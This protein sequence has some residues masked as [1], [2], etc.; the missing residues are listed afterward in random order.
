ME[1]V[2]KKK[3]LTFQMS[4]TG[5]KKSKDGHRSYYECGRT[6]VHKEIDSI[7]RSIK[8]QGSKKI[9][10][11]CTSHIILFEH[12]NKSSC[13]VIFY[14]YH[15]GHQESELQHISLPITKKH[16]IATKLSQGVTMERILD[17]FRDNI[18]SN[19]KREDLITR[20]DLHNVK[21]KYNITIQDGQLH[22]NDATR[23]DIW[24]EQMKQEGENNP[25]I[26]YKKCPALHKKTILK[27]LHY[28]NGP[29]PNAYVKTIWKWKN[30]LYW[31][32][33]L[34]AYDFEL[35]TLLVVDD[36]GS[37]FP[38]CYMFTNL[39]DTTIYTVMFS[40]IKSKVGLISPITFMTDIVETFYSAWEN[41]MGSVPHRL[42]CSWHVDRAWRQNICKITGPTRKEKQGII[43]K[44]LK[45]LQSMCDENEFNNA[46]KEFN[47][48]LMNDPDTRDFGIYFDRMYGNRVGL[49]AYCHRKGLGINC[50]MHLESMHK[51][52]KYH[53]LNGCKVGRLD[54]SITTIRRYTR[55]KKVERI[56][57]LTKGKT[58]TRIQEIKKRHNK[59]T[60][61]ELTI[62]LDSENNWSV[63]SEFT[64][65][66]FYKIKKNNDDVCCPMICS[67]CKLCVH[68]FQC[69]CP[70]YQIKS[71]I[72][73]HI[74]YVALKTMSTENSEDI[75]I[76]SAA[77]T[78]NIN[79]D[80]T[81][82]KDDEIQLLDFYY[83]ASY[84]PWPQ[85][86]LIYRVK[87]LN[88]F[89][90]NNGITAIRRLFKELNSI[91]PSCKQLYIEMISYEQSL[92]S[93]NITQVSKLYNEVCYN[94]GHGDVELWAHYIRFEYMHIERYTAK[95][96]YKSSLEYLGPELFGVLTTE[97]GNIKSEYE[98]V[99]N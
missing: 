81:S 28:I 75:A 48:E 24:V 1:Y 71:M 99:Y 7:K 10:T 45:V 43:Y 20:A 18:G 3:L 8:S 31:T 59:S 61:L 25:V 60:L 51:T 95:N 40:T 19:L 56:I 84:V 33:G 37:G 65:S 58:S 14:K 98:Y 93:V 88:I 70:D 21:Q 92:S 6:G 9:N 12:L 91:S 46:L 62:N 5:K 22:K 41:T 63:E 73:K 66:Q 90:M 38:C 50:N 34:N 77:D 57:K 42:L 97:F 32:H 17:D 96:I 79:F 83:Q 2:L 94:L 16:E 74:H 26:Y 78:E 15:Y 68:T 69:S 4:L 52:I 64:P 49:W 23:V 89:G 54:K 80:A 36:F 35:V 39:K 72:C 55:D 13:E 87:Y 30:S 53:Y 44:T 67:I 76:L 86:N 11:N 29:K 47:L 85:I 27:L 82:N